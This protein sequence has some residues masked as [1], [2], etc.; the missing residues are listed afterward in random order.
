M[1]HRCKARKFYDSLNDVEDSFTVAF[2]MM[3]NLVLPKSAIRQSYYSR[4]LYLYLF[5]VVHHR[6]RNQPQGKED[7]HLYVWCE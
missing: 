1:L 7:I 4:Q 2:D 6:G 3:E 5:G